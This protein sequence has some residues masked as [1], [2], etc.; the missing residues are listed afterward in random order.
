MAVYSI[1]YFLLNI[2]FNLDHKILQ[3]YNDAVLVFLQYSDGR[4]SSTVHVY[5][6]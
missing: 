3:R 4:V 5:G 6:G 1:S 2:F